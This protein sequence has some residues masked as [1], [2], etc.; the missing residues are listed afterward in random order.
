MDDSLPDW[1]RQ[2]RER[3]E[4]LAGPL[5]QFEVPLVTNR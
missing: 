4:H 5:Q 3:L 2:L 1:I